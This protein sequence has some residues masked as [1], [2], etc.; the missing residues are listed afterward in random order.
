MTDSA[1][2]VLTIAAPPA[3]PQPA[4]Q[5]SACEM[6]AMA[7]SSLPMTA[8]AAS[9]APMSPAVRPFGTPAEM[10]YMAASPMQISSPAVMAHMSPA[11]ED[12][13][14][15]QQPIAEE[16]SF[17]LAN[18]AQ[19]DALQGAAPAAPA[20][21]EPT[22]PAGTP[23]LTQGTAAT[24]TPTQ[25]PRSAV[26]APRSASMQGVAPRSA[27]K[28]PLS[29]LKPSATKT[30]VGQRATPV[31]P[32]RRAP[33][34]AERTNKGTAAKSALKAS[35]PAA[36]VVT[37]TGAKATATSFA[38][39]VAGQRT[40]KHV[41]IA[42]PVGSGSTASRHIVRTPYPRSGSK[43]PVTWAGDALETEE[44]PEDVNDSHIDGVQ[45]V[46]AR[47]VAM[48]A[49]CAAT[50]I[51][52]QP[53]Q[54]SA[55]DDP[56]ARLVDATM[57]LAAALPPSYRNTCEEAPAAQQ[58]DQLAV[59]PTMPTAATPVPAMVHD[60][61]MD[62]DM[63]EP[64]AVSLAPSGAFQ[65]AG[66]PDF[67]SLSARVAATP[68][69]IATAPLYTPTSARMQMV[70]QHTVQYGRV[71]IV[72]ALYVPHLLSDMNFV[73]TQR[74]SNACPVHAYLCLSCRQPRCLA[75]QLLVPPPQS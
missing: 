26:R 34:T 6:D 30:P 53:E 64:A 9:P 11:V 73:L 61:G 52:T 3:S 28:P 2:A 15:P 33:A 58:A 35:E 27:A 45:P 70:S 42:T 46:A 43:T 14:A 7:I 13:C 23:V 19:A 40:A 4:L 31:V 47:A 74:G 8:A 10:D 72:P 63:D 32:S 44:V 36:P 56:A 12:S 48:Q 41:S 59:T 22:S 60:S 55:I 25:V 20:F 54:Q 21:E 49:T 17:E 29:A 24:A 39:K 51:D 69:A 1:A 57:Q 65:Q 50:P 5:P 75:G 67:G 68:M 16:F 18:S 37:P 62:L 71:S 38:S 66:T